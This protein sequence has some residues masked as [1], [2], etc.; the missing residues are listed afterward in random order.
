MYTNFKPAWME[1]DHV[2]SEWV[3]DGAVI[4]RHVQASFRIV[5]FTHLRSD[6]GRGMYNKSSLFRVKE[7]KREKKLTKKEKHEG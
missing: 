2:S 1:K 7:K 3:G 6:H 5:K 4:G